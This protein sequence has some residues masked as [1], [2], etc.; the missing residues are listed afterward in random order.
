MVINY[1]H[2]SNRSVI[3]SSKTSRNKKK[4]KTLHFSCFKFKWFWSLNDPAFSSVLYFAHL[5]ETRN[6]STLP[7]AKELIIRTQNSKK[8][9]LRANILPSRHLL[10]T[11]SRFSRMPLSFAGPLGLLVSFPPRYIIS[12]PALAKFSALHI[13]LI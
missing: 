13:V 12:R 1:T 7:I 8:K 10:S 11:A 3:N 6:D 2:Y 5:I 9:I 4:I